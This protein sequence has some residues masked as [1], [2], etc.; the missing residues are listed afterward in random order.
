MIHTTIG[1]YSN[2]AYNVNGVDSSNLANHIN[3]NIQKRPGRALI[4]DTFVVYKG[5][6][7][8]DVLNSNIRNFIKIK[9]TEDTYPYK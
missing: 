5:I 4:V 2:G 1:L 9:K 6:G 8:N 7:C 3:Y